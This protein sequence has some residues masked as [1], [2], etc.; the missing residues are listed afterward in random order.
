MADSTFIGKNILLLQKNRR[1]SLQGRGVTTSLGVVVMWGRVDKRIL[2]S[3]FNLD[4]ENHLPLIASTFSRLGLKS[5]I[6]WEETEGGIFDLFLGYLEKD[7]H[8][9]YALLDP[10]LSQ[11]QAVILQLPIKLEEYIKMMAGKKYFALAGTT[12]F[13]PDPESIGVTRQDDHFLSVIWRG[14][15]IAPHDWNDFASY[16]RGNLK[17]AAHR[18]DIVLTHVVDQQPNPFVLDYIRWTKEKL[19]L[20][21]FSSHDPEVFDGY[22]VYAVEIESGSKTK[23]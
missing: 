6:G 19:A 4:I 23:S 16:A 20:G 1:N 10:S 14:R 3:G 12:Y 21:D 9:L 7:K 2:D 22:T 18:R 5:E 17:A 15:N 13:L 8:C 11:I